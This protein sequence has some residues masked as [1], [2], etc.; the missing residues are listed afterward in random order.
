M[1]GLGLG[2]ATAP[3][4]RR[5]RRKRGPVV[6]LVLLVVLAMLVGVSVIGVRALSQRLAGPADYAGPGTGQVVVEVTAGQ[7]LSGIGRT[8]ADKGVVKSAEAFS[9]VAK[10]DPQAQSVQPGFYRL[11]TQMSASGALTLLLDPTSVVRNRV[12]IPEGTPSEQVLK[13]VA[14]KTGLK[15]ADLAA[16]AKDTASLG[17]PSWAVGKH[18]EGFL[19]PATY[20]FGPD[21]TAQSVLSTMV[22]RFVKEADALDLVGGAAALGMT[23]YQVLTVAS[24]VEKEAGLPKDFPKVSRVAY[25]RLAISM[26]L[27]FDSTLNYALAERKSNLSLNDLKTESPYN[28]YQVSG[29]PPTPISDPGAVALKAALQ[30]TPGDWLYFVTIDKAGNTAFSTSYDQFLKDKAVGAKA[31]SAQ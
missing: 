2:T 3:P 9:Q 18:V 14:A 7:S 22:A 8:L 17:L 12:T 15:L 23:P 19:F 26:K 29:L 16:A 30:P 1:A 27:Q 6:G 24:M 21:A 31:L 10:G 4:P 28:T 5:R 20:D 13:I 11:K 25:N